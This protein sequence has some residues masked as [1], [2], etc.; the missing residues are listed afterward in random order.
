MGEY[1]NAD[2]AG[3]PFH[4]VNSPSQGSFYDGYSSPRAYP[5]AIQWGQNAQQWA[6]LQ[7]NIQQGRFSTSNSVSWDTQHRDVLVTLTR[8]PSVPPT[9][10]LPHH[11]QQPNEDEPS[12]GPCCIVM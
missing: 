4:A 10:T 8:A 9:Q 1:L 11:L 7:N 2:A 6:P 5:Q 12:C 3:L